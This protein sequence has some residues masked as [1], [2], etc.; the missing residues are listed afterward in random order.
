MKITSVIFIF[1]ASIVTLTFA[2][3][4]SFR[5]VNW[6]QD[7]DND[8][9]PACAGSNQSPINIIRSDTIHLTESDVKP[10]RHACGDVAGKLIN[11]GHTIKF[12]TNDGNPIVSD[13]S[14]MTG[15]PL[16]DTKYHF[17]QFHLHWGFWNCNGSE[18]T[19]DNSR[20]PA[21]LHL[22]HVREDFL[23]ANGSIDP[24][25]FSTPGGLS[26]LGIFLDTVSDHSAATSW[27][28]VSLKN[29]YSRVCL[30]ILV[31]LQPIADAA[32]EI[33]D[34]KDSSKIIDSIDFNLNQISQRI[35]PTFK[36]HFNYWYYDG[37]LT[38]PDCNEIV[39]WII[40]EKPLTITNAQVK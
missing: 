22:V 21:E 28:H 25:A 17:W 20:F 33:V 4:Y 39:S 8:F 3:D 16:N 30:I 26:V 9:N 15:G 2:F 37:S 6:A 18:H 35:N 27:F 14:Y 13:H 23:Q 38:T 40:A 31:Y 29:N 5:G 11:N 1:L 34:C 7:G 19:V 12:E 10:M 24:V 36:G 32:Q